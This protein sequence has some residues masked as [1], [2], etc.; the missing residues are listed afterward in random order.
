MARVRRAV[1]WTRDDLN[2]AVINV[3]TKVLSLRKAS[4]VFNVPVRIIRGHLKTEL[5]EAPGRPAVFNRAEEAALTARLKRLTKIGYGVT[6]MEIRKLVFDFCQR[7]GKA[8]PFTNGMA[9]RK[10]LRGFLKRNQGLSIRQ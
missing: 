4:Q 8:T 5:R 7:S 3:P 1:K 10:W 2:R 6:I 9:G